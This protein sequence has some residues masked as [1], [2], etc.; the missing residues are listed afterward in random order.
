MEAPLLAILLSQIDLQYTCCEQLGVKVNFS[1]IALEIAYRKTV[2]HL[3]D[4]RYAS[5]KVSDLLEEV[6]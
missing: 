4:L 3:D 1:H 2:A 5:T 6:N